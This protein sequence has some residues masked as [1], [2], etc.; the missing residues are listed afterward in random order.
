MGA[1]ALLL[2]CAF[3]SLCSGSCISNLGSAL[4]EGCEGQLGCLVEP[5]GASCK[6]IPVAIL[7]PSNPRGAGNWVAFPSCQRA[8]PI[9]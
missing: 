6:P 3:L 5:P 4:E 8:A 7:V 2:L 1:A 9:G